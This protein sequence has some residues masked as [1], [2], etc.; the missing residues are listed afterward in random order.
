MRD[1]SKEFADRVQFIRNLVET[2]G[3]DGI[4]YGNSGGK[5]C[6]LVGILCKF[7]CENTVGIMMP[8]ASKRNFESDMNDAKEVAEHFGIESRVIDLTDVRQAEIERLQGITTLTNAAVNN[9][10]PRLRMTTLYAVAA[11]EYRLV[12]GTGNRSERYMGYYTKWGDGAC[13]F[14]PISDLTATEVIEFLK[15]LTAPACVINKAPS[16]G[17]FEGQTDENEMGVT[18]NAIDRYILTGEAEERDRKIIDRFHR[19][20]AHKRRGITLYKEI[21]E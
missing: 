2:S 17:L 3:V 9:I 19:N 4:V 11:S 16:A 12:A 15:W 14:N 21:E 7:A 1:Y 10:A 20:S 13:D 5:D 8:C 6:A 18:Y